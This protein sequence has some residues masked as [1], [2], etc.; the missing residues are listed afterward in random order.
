MKAEFGSIVIFPGMLGRPEMIMTYNVE[1]T[2][3]VFN[4]S[5]IN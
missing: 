3:K 2:E 4:H 1:D 5:T